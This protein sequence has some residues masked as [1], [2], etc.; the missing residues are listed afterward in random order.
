MNKTGQRIAVIGAGISGLGA[1]WALS[2]HH[3]VTVFEANAYPGGH[4]N[5]V[6]VD[7]DGTPIAVDTGF[8]VF[9]DWNYPNLV[10]LFAHLNVPNMPSDMSFAISVG[11]GA[12]RGQLE[13]NGSNLASLFAQ[14][15]NLLRPSFHRMWRDILRFN[16]STVADL[17]AGALEGISLGDYLA[18]EGYSETFTL[19]YLLPMGAAIWSAPMAEMMAF[20]AVT[21]ARFF[22]NHGLLSVN[23]RPQWRTVQGGSR[24]YVRRLLADSKL[25]LRLNTPVAS[26]SR[27]TEGV[28]LAG[29]QGPLGRFDQVLLACHGDQALRI[30]GSQ[31]TAQE[32]DILGCFRFQPN[33]AV[34]HRDVKQMP[35]RRAAWA[36]WNYL[37]EPRRD[38]NR[39]VGLTY[40]MN[41]LQSI[42]PG[43]PLF[44]TMNPIEQPDPK[45][46]FARFEYEHPLFDRAAVAAQSRL[47][48][49]QGKQRLWFA[50]AWAGY[51]FH[52]D[53]FT[54]GLRV[55]EALGAPAP[56]A[57]D[58]RQ[59][60]LEAAE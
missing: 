8:I 27:D 44:V 46:V 40:W 11:L 25:D 33:I 19:D 51:G 17:E 16:R 47:N 3:A 32:R 26:L 43:K 56:F 45:L 42:D 1:A 29:P 12:T 38:L 50:G 13:W 59:R 53:G 36:S 39:R 4:S 34:L 20:P 28:S 41:K 54:A 57:A 49:I 30:L 48:D 2:R 18:R 31:A 21:F 6:Q 14:K 58:S 35:V 9:N 23:D 55:A 37:S 60:L 22:R 15:R 5:T 52:E 7:Y 24:E 10:K